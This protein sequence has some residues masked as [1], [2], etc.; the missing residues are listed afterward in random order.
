MN[1]RGQ[2]FLIAAFVIVGILVGLV[3]VYT[4]AETLPED[5][6]VFDISSQLNFEGASV[7]DHGSFNSLSRQDKINHL[8]SITDSYAKLNPG[9]DFII[10]YGNSSNL[11]VTTYTSQDTGTV[12]LTF[13]SQPTNQFVSHQRENV[14]ELDPQGQNKVTILIDPNDK[15]VRHTFDLKPGETFFIIAKEEKQGERYVATSL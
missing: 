3:T 8:K 9:T 5:P 7:I 1:K 12:G 2:F 10:I 15:N 13:G 6:T 4:S 14:Y 11:S